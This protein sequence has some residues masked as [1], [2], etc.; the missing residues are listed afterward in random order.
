MSTSKALENEVLADHVS[1]T[2]STQDRTIRRDIP[3]I[4]PLSHVRMS[5]S[6]TIVTVARGRLLDGEPR[7]YLDYSPYS[8]SPT[9]AVNSR[10]PSPTKEIHAGY[11]CDISCRRQDRLK[12]RL[13]SGFFAVFL[14][15]WADGG[16][17]ISNGIITYANGTISQ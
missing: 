3:T 5:N 17:S 6:A 7:P 1:S 11:E 9:T 8:S 10:A 12:W 14:C 2:L 15:G 4:S 16:K 13:A